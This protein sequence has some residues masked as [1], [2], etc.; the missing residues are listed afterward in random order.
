MIDILKNLGRY[1]K[2]L[3]TSIPIE[4]PKKAI[5]GP[6]LDGEEYYI[7]Y[8]PDSVPEPASE[9]PKGDPTSVDFGDGYIAKRMTN[10]KWAVIDPVRTIQYGEPYY[11]DLVSKSKYYSWPSSCKFFNDCQGSLSRIQKIIEYKTGLKFVKDT[12]P[13]KKQRI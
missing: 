10:E 7:Q 8:G 5:T 13:I 6:V 12:N 11:I 3:F 2:G 9:A 4:Q 1:T